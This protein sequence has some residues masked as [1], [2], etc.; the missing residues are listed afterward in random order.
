MCRKGTWEYGPDLPAP[1]YEGCAVG[2]HLGLV[3]IGE[4][5]DQAG[6]NSYIL[7]DT[8][9][10]ALPKSNYEHVNPGCGLGR[11]GNR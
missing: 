5:E 10:S 2:T 4:F 9:W 11:I 7:K 6:T 3:V 8:V 1:L